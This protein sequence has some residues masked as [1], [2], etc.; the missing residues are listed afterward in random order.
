MRIDAWRLANLRRTGSWSAIGLWREKQSPMRPIY[1]ISAALLGSLILIAV[2]GVQP[3]AAQRPPVDAQC[4]GCHDDTNREIT[5]PSGESLSIHILLDQFDGSVHGPSTHGS[6]EG[7]EVTCTSCHGDKLRYRYPH[8]PNPAQTAQEFR[9]QVSESCQN[10]HYPHNP[11]HGDLTTAQQPSCADC[12]GSHAMPEIENLLD[13]MPQNCVTCHVDQ[14]TEWAASYIAPRPGLGAGAAG[15]IGSDRCGGCH[16]ELYASWKETTHSHLIQDVQAQP[17]AVLGDFTSL[18]ADRTFELDGVRY[19]VGSKWRQQYLARDA[20]DNFWVLPGQ[21]NVQTE[22]WVPAHEGLGQ[23]S[24]WRQSCGSCH[25]TGLNTTNWEFSEFSVGCEACH[26]PGEAHVANPKEV[27]PYSK[28]DDQVC[29]ACHSRGTSP[30]GYDFPAAYKPGDLLIDHFTFATGDEDLWPDGSAKMN[31]QQYQ[32]FQLDS[33][34]SQAAS[35]NCTVCHLPHEVGP[36][37]GQLRAAPEKL[38]LECHNDQRAIVDHTPFHQKALQVRNFT[39][40][41]CHMPK[42]ATSAVDYDIRS[43]SFLQP[44]PQGSLDH[45]GLEMMPNAC[46]QCHSDFGEDAVWAAQTIASARE[47]KPLLVASFY[48]PGPTPTSPPPPTPLASVGAPAEHV[49][50]ETGRWLRIGFFV[51]LGLLLLAGVLFVVRLVIF[52]RTVNV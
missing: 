26:G 27:K 39:C 42:M 46:N 15:Y 38:C 8:Q 45:G 33:R 6:I 50:V 2:W 31:H 13:F 14:S 37:S 34:K 23:K 25:V 11:L 51:V 4:R 18:D 35:M 22:E 52:R 20:E 7:A 41:D 9:V 49:Q 36:A 17:Q 47:F 19:T 29:G 3:V 21:W 5:L 16:E 30:E 44:D 12:H 1:H 24:E 10:C 43:H 32:D 40:V 48:G 28:V